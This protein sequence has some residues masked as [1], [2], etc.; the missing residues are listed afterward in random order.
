MGKFKSIKSA[1]LSIVLPLVIVG[2]III[3]LIGYFYSKSVINS[4]ISENMD[5]QINYITEGIEK[6]LS[7]H[8]QLAFE[9]LS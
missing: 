2:M 1:L 5:S 3:S 6:S 7:N 9:Y 4:E 8:N